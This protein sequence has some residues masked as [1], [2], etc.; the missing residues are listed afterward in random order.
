VSVSYDN[1]S[2][3]EEGGEEE[4]FLDLNSNFST[5]SLSGK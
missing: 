3:L 4:E 2:E 1:D 5:I